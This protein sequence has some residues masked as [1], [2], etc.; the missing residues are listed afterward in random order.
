MAERR[1]CPG[2]E[3]MAGSFGGWEEVPGCVTAAE[4]LPGLPYEF[5]RGREDSVTRGATCKYDGWRS[6]QCGA[7]PADGATAIM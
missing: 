4:G 6:H 5:R 3:Q 1:E 7:S 2:G